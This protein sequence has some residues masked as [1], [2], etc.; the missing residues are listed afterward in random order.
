VRSGVLF[1]R[2]VLLV[3]QATPAIAVAT[4]RVRTFTIAFIDI[5]SSR[6]LMVQRTYLPHRA[7]VVRAA[8]KRSRLG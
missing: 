3:A 2:G 8:R 7:R 6:A 4:A 5:T 1:A